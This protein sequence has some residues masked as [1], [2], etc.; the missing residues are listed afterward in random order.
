[1]SNSITFETPNKAMPFKRL[2]YGDFFVVPARPTTLYMCIPDVRVITIDP[3]D[4]RK[5]YNCIHMG[6]CKLETRDP[7]EL[8]LKCSC[9]IKASID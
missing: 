8:V 3:Y 5:K 6:A 7:D 9:N 4:D 1:M 2:H